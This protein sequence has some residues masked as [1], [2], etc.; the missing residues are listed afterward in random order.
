V[1][2]GVQA[3]GSVALLA[4][5]GPE[6][7]PLATRTPSLAE[8]GTVGNVRVVTQTVGI[9]LAAAA[10]GTA[11]AVADRRLRAV[12]MIGTCGAYEGA[13][14]AIGDVVVSRRVRLADASVLAGHA[15]FPGPMTTSLDGDAGLIEAL[16]RAGAQPVD[17]A[18]TLAISVDDA[19]AARIAHGARSSVEHLEAFGAGMACAAFGV[20]FV[21]V[22]GVANRVGA[23]ARSEWREH[24]VHASEAC[25]GVVIAWL[26]ALRSPEGG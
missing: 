21:A 25:V 16:A 15:D 26:T 12:V 17:V 19:L 1:A 23:R 10:A 20:P 13:S 4:A 7:A 14:L 6:L 24:H 8:T 18:T 9:G 3:G 11:R 22:L 2:D 5:F